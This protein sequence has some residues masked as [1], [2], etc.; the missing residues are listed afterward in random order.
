MSKTVP[1][2][3]GSRGKDGVAAPNPTVW[4]FDDFTLG[5]DVLARTIAEQ[6]NFPCC[7]MRQ[8]DVLSPALEIP[9]GDI[10]LASADGL[11]Q[12]MLLRAVRTVSGRYPDNPLVLFASDATL[13]GL[14]SV[15]DLGVQ[16]V[17]PKSLPAV[18]I[19]AALE[20]VA[21]GAAYLPQQLLKKTVPQREAIG[22]TEAEQKVLA[23][24]AKGST[25]LQLADAFSMP[26]TTVKMHVRNICRKLGV[27]NRTSAVLKAQQMGLV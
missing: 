16:G 19:I 8:R 2:C 25:N 10:F 17:I 15:A 13:D 18:N 14:G 27:R 4:I 5:C 24:L 7:H 26:I 23:G 21:H 20:L 9:P 1:V 22:L 3:Y 11:P 12:R 6:G